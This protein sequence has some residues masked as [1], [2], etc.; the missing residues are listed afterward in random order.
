M[1]LSTCYCG[2]LGSQEQQSAVGTGYI[3]ILGSGA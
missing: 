2:L 1:G 3:F